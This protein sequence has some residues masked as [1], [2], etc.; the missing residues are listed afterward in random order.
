LPL[1]NILSALKEKPN[2]LTQMLVVGRDVLTWRKL[3]KFTSNLP[4][5]V[6]DATGP[7][8]LYR[9]IFPRRQIEVD[10]ANAQMVAQVWQIFDE[11]L[12]TGVSF[13]GP[14]QTR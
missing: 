5:V 3:H 8:R 12:R 7:E 10:E 13:P 11:K 6:L 2:K 14:R 1:I 9:P 4:V